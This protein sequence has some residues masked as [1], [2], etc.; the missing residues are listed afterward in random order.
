MNPNPAVAIRMPRLFLTLAMLLASLLLA[1]CKVA[2]PQIASATVTRYA[3]GV[4][5]PAREIGPG[6]RAAVAA[7]FEARPTGWRVSSGT[8]SPTLEL[9]L[10]HPDQSASLI[11]L[12]GSRVIVT[13][14]FGQFERRTSAAA[15]AQLRRSMQPDP[16]IP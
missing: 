9:R 15:M 5:G 8:Y 11:H 16:P 2:L 13:G 4:A 7:W 10:V 6:Q 12:A 1:G 3:A 14:P